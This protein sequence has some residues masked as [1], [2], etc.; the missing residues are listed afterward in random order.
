MTDHAEFMRQAIALAYQGMEGGHGGPFGAVIVRDGAVIGTG[1]NRVLSAMDPTAHAE[2]TAIRDASARVRHFDLSGST[3][4]VNG[5]PCPMC[6]SAIFW[7]RIGAV[8]YG[9][10]PADA[11]AIGFD[12]QEFYRQLA[13]PEGERTTPATQMSECYDEAKACY[14]AWLTRDGRTNY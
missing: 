9:C 10:G 7:A 11:E 8:Y 12:D 13:M 2:V 14:A 4:Y 1:H 5:M 3:I 6:M